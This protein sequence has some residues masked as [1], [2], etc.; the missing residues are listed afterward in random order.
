MEMF[1]WLHHDNTQQRYINYRVDKA[2]L[3][4]TKQN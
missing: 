4:T 1:S 2:T 3:D